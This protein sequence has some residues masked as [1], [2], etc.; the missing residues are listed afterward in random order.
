M[1]SQHIFRSTALSV[2]A[3]LACG[4][5]AQAQTYGAATGFTPYGAG[6]RPSAY[7]FYPL[8]R[9]E[10]TYG[11]AVYPRSDTYL[12][13]GYGPI[14]L[15]SINYPGVYGAFTYGIYASAFNIAPTISA[16]MYPPA[17]MEGFTSTLRTATSP[18]D[19][20]AAIDVR[21][22]PTAEL[23][24]DGVKTT[25]TGD[26][27]TFLTPPL[28]PGRDFSYTVQAVWN[29]RGQTVR[30]QRM[31]RVRAGDHLRVDFTVAGPTPGLRTLSTLNTTPRP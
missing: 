28:V 15:T 22:H 3:L 16:G 14:F 7:G 17:T 25:Q 19:V 5:L 8:S 6:V 4:T 27:R 13:D 29:N 31:L 2:L 18:G 11:P 10:P 23:F 9:T 12:G 1:F 20:S 21:I 30:E 24:F 26:N